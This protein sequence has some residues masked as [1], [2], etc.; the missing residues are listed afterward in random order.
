MNHEHEISAFGGHPLKVHL[1]GMRTSDAITAPPTDLAGRLSELAILDAEQLVALT[2]TEDRREKLADS[3]GLGRYELENIVEDARSVLPRNLVDELSTPLPPLYALG[4][5]PPPAGE[6]APIAAMD[7]PIAAVAAATSANLISYMSPIRNQGS[8]GTCVAFTVTAIHE[9]YRR[10]KGSEQN[11][12]E[13]HLYHETKLLDGAPAVCGTW[14]RVAAQALSGR[15]QC[16][17]TVW[18]Y[19]PNPPCNNNGTLPSNARSDAAGFKL[20]LHSLTPTSVSSLKSALAQ[21]RPVGISIPVYNSWYSS[22]ETRRSGRITMPLLNDQQVGGHA[23]CAVGYQESPS[24]PGG[25]YFLV[26]NHW[27][28]SWGYQNPYGAGYGTIPFEY[29]SRFNW[30]AYALSGSVGLEEEKKGDEEGKNEDRRN[31]AEPERTIHI[32]ARGNVRIVIE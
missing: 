6:E 9:Y 27:S 20:G 10:R 28:T 22:A 1:R 15:G 21:G 17:E 11:L 19:N 26:R 14:Q 23:I 8:R 30:E 18:P 29:I 31:D 32:R 13:Q 3:L 5:M 12:S 24:S 4:A 2:G 16:R 25:G 7:E